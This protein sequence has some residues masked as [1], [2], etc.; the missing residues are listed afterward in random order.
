NEK[1]EHFVLTLYEAF[2]LR[3]RHFFWQ[4]QLLTEFSTQFNIEPI[5]IENIHMI[6]NHCPILNSGLKNDTVPIVDG[7]KMDYKIPY[8]KEKRIF[9]MAN[10]YAPR[11][12]ER[13]TYPKDVEVLYCEKCRKV[14]KKIIEA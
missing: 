9:P 1:Y 6:F 13:F 7:N 3:D 8:E 5:N 10:I 11:D 2:P 14:R 4:E 12:L